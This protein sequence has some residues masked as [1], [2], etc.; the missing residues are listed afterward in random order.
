MSSVPGLKIIS[1]DRKQ[2]LW[3]SLKNLWK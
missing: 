2:C 3:Y 1:T